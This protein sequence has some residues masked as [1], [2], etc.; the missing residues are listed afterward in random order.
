MLDSFDKNK[1][2]ETDIVFCLDD[3][4]PFF[5]EYIHLFETKRERYVIYYDKRTITQMFNNIATVHD[6]GYDI[7]HMAN[8]DF[9]YR[10]KGFDRIVL[11][12]VEEHGTGVYYGNDRFW[13]K[14][15][16]VAPFVTADLVQALGWLQMPRLV[17]LCGDTVW[18]EIGTQLGKLY[19]LPKIVID[20]IH[21][22]TKKIKKDSVS[23]RVNSAEMYRLDY[24]NYF[25][26]DKYNKEKDLDKCRAAL[27]SE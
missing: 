17:H 21:P 26:W 8:D 27:G 25:L 24:L 20:H 23:L 5:A 18:T 6:I 16:A 7:Y 12:A 2:E 4:D 14:E 19:Y 22:E 11:E 3:D 10:T 9:I 13:G 15:I 1:T